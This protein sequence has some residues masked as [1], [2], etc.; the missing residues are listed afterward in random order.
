MDS[1]YSTKLGL[2]SIFGDSEEHIEAYQLALALDFDWG[3]LKASAKKF[4][5]KISNPVFETGLTNFKRKIAQKRASGINLES[6]HLNAVTT[7]I[8]WEEKLSENCLNELNLYLANKTIPYDF[9]EK[10]NNLSRQ[11]GRDISARAEKSLLL[12]HALPHAFEVKERTLNMIK[13]LN[14]WQ[15]DTNRDKFLRELTGCIAF[16]HD[17]E[18]RNKSVMYESNEEATVEPVAA[19]LC[20]ALGISEKKPIRQLIYYMSHQVIVPGT[21]FLVGKGMQAAMDLRE[22]HLAAKES[23]QSQISSGNSRRLSNQVFIADLCMVTQAIG[24]N[25]KQPAAVLLNVRAQADNPALE[26]LALIKAH[27]SDVSRLCCFFSEKDKE[28]TPWFTSYYPDEKLYINAQAF[29]MAM[30]PH[31]CMPS[32]FMSEGE[33]M[34][35]DY[36]RFLQ[37]CRESYAASQSDFSIIFEQAF[38]NYNMEAVM[39]AV[40]FNHN[41]IAAE[42]LFSATQIQILKLNDERFVDASVP[43]TDMKNLD[44]LKAFYD[45][46]SKD[47]KTALLKELIMGVVLQAGQMLAFDFMPAKTNN[48]EFIRATSRSNDRFF[49]GAAFPDNEASSASHQLPEGAHST[50]VTAYQDSEEKDELRPLTSLGRQDAF[51][52]GE[53]A[54][55]TEEITY[56]R[57]ENFLACQYRKTKKVEKVEEVESNRKSSFCLIS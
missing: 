21:T 12:H 7:T 26:T 9:D 22:L 6:K 53:N 48:K 52:E 57:L 15:A 25:D 14:V 51:K 5:E 41:R 11:C 37:V 13:A 2:K 1:G 56:E 36:Y 28:N 54:E 38:Q 8:E 34:R 31:L 19:K 27:C 33:P 44:G 55:L 46:S 32:E 49:K 24:V 42:K 39:Q 29:L 50:Q 35:K 40:L 17:Y 3:D 10:I 20:E 45:A 47:E 16:L 43:R 23:T 4:L 18:Q 30:P